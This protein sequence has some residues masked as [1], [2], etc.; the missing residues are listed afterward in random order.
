MKKALTLLFLI[1]LTTSLFA[2]KNLDISLEEIAEPTELRSTP[3]QPTQ[4]TIRLV[5]KNNGP[6]IL[7]VGDTLA[8]FAVI[9]DLGTP[10]AY[11]PIQVPANAVSGNRY[12]RAITEDVPVGDTISV[13]IAGTLPFYLNFSRDA[14]VGAYCA[15]YNRASQPTDANTGNNEAIRDIVFWNTDRNGVSVED[16]NY[17]NNI[18]LYPNPANTNLNIRLLSVQFNDVSVELIDITGKVILSENV[19]TSL[20]DAGYTI[21]VS[22]IPNG[23]YIV[24]V[25]NG[26]QINTSK[27]SI[28]H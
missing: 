2:Q 15:A 11:N 23:M 25:T 8:W 22:N 27:V 9:Q 7:A 3:P 24:R 28:A 12:L 21:D 17:S 13:G 5:C 1:G 16:L 20:S 19:S 6:D 18:A 10:A 14:R 26:D 4:V